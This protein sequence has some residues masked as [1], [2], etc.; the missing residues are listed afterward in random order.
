[1]DC[2]VYRGGYKYQLKA[3]Y[4]VQVEIRP[5]SDIASEFIALDCDGRLTIRSGYAWDGPS[6]PTIP[7]LSFLRGSLIHDALYQLIREGWLFLKHR[8]AADKILRRVCIEDGMSRIRAWWVYHAVR[9]FGNPAA[10]PAC[11]R[12]CMTA[13]DGC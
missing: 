8:E 6:G 4:Q 13:P 11:T 10:D 9:V 3:T 5:E 2:I 7:T 1:M 12:P